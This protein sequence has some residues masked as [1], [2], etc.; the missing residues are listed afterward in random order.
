MKI[1]STGVPGI[2]IWAKF[3][4]FLSHIINKHADL[5]DPLFNK[6]HHGDIPPKNR[7]QASMYIML[8][9]HYSI[10]FSVLANLSSA[11]LNAITKEYFTLISH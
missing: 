4:S 5:D 10:L 1:I 11:F 2:V 6:C 9:F 8:F 3:Q 7:L